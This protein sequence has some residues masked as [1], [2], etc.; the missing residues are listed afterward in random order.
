MFKAVAKSFFLVLVFSLSNCT[1][2]E[3]NPVG[4]N[5]APVDPTISNNTKN[6]YI[7]KVFIKLLDRKADSIEFKAALELLNQDPGSQ[8]KRKEVLNLIKANPEYP[9][10]MWKNIQRALVRW[11]RYGYHK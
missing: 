10:V 3:I 11:Y 9:H 4:G 2:E 8:S 7:N 5:T 1:K 6:N